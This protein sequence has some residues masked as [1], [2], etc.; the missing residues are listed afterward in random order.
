MQ[1]PNLF[2]KN[3]SKCSI[4]TEQWDKIAHKMYIK[5][6]GLSLT[7]Y[8]DSKGYW[9]FGI[10]RF[11]GRELTSLKISEHIAKEMLDEDI[12]TALS[13]A[14]DIF[15]EEYFCSIEPPRQFAILNM[16]FM[17]KARF[18]GFKKM[19]EAIL[20]EDWERAAR[21]AKDSKWASDVDPRRQEN[22]GR[23]DRVAFML[24]EGKFHDYYSVG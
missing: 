10:G 5:D 19:I 11:I 6:E 14:F 12:N 7:P 4:R 3:P 13:D 15:T 17:G 9:T 2:K 21:E 18:M 23:D 22:A 8:R 1:I 20:R 24:R 16:L